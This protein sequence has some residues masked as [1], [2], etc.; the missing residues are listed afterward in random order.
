VAEREWL[1]HFLFFLLPHPFHFSGV[2]LILK[3]TQLMFESQK[4][5]VSGWSLFA[6]TVRPVWVDNLECGGLGWLGVVLKSLLTF[7]FTSSLFTSRKS[8]T[9]SHFQ[10]SSDVVC[11]AFTSSPKCICFWSAIDSGTICR[12]SSGF[13]VCKAFSAGD[14]G[15]H[16]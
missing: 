1:D 8:C 6:L 4:S 16:F 14:F 5:L 12:C 13:I 15:I 2:Y 7:L 3:R 9:L 11:L 10:T